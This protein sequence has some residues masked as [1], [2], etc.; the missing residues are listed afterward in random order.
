MWAAAG[1]GWDGGGGHQ[2]PLP[3]VMT[4]RI[5]DLAEG[6]IILLP[7]THRI[8]SF[9]HTTIRLITYITLCSSYTH[10]DTFTATFI[11]NI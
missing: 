2:L 8:L 11:Q 9:Q 6:V 1:S 4:P 3:H 10:V 5:F 7:A